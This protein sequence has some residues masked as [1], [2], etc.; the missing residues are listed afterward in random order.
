MQ[1]IKMDSIQH[2]LD[3]ITEELRDLVRS[4]HDP[5]PDNGEDSTHGDLSVSYHIAK[6]ESSR[7]AVD[8]EKWLENNPDPALKVHMLPKP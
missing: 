8:L 4:S 2:V 1:L 3:R 7:V 6:E 5:E